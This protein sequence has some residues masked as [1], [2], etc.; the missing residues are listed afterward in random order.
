MRKALIAGLFVVVF[1]GGAQANAQSNP[2][3]E[4]GISRFKMALR[5]TAEQHKHWPR[6]EAAL[7][8]MVREQSADSED[9]GV[10]S[11]VRN[12]VGA[13]ASQAGSMGRLVAAA[14]P[15]VNSL[16]EG[17]KRDAMQ[18][19]RSMGFASLAARFE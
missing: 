15:L 9:A 8:A 17:Q 1:L 6:V 13:Y 19:A 12:R 7:R 10:V 16:D 3:V 11:R 5:L 14:R 2:E 4:S 18:L